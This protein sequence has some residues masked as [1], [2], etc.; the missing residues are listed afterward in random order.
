MRTIMTITI[1][2]SI[3]GSGKTTFMINLINQLHT[4]ALGQS[5]NHPS[6]ELPR[7]LYVAPLLSEVDRINEKCPGLN[8]RDP[9]PKEGRKLH[10]LSTLID[11]GSNI[12]TTHAL[13]RLLTRDI[14]EKLKRQNYTLIIDE[15][16]DCVNLFEGLSTSDRKLL[17]KD[18]CVYVDPDS[19][20]LRWNHRDH[21]NYSGEFNAIRDL[22]DNGNLV[23]H[24][25]KTL[26]WEFPT[27]FLKCF[28]QVYVLTYMFHGSPMSAYLRAEALTFEMM[29]LRDHQLVS[30]AE[31]SNETWKKE[32]LRKLITV[33]DGPANACGKAKGREN[34]FSSG[35]YEKMIKR[36]PEKLKAVKATTEHWFKSMAQTPA[37][38]NAWTTLKKAR[39]HLKGDR[40]ARGFIPNNAK[41]TNA[42]REKKS[43]AYLCNV[44]PNPLIKGYF[45]DRKT[46]V[47]DDLYAL[48][49]M[50]QWIWRTQI[51]DDQPINVFIPSE[52]MRNLFNR[53]L[54]SAS[55]ADLIEPEFKQAA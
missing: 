5:F 38:D 1:I 17:F 37:S 20:R 10:H 13:F 22:C 31:H 40:Y 55:V 44:F 33:Y 39:K 2:D 6:H 52:R 25:D 23:L 3:M 45:E 19:K 30:W 53:W 15:V 50:I 42:Y 32:E 14:Y 21:P 11:E 8:F 51:R 36:S 54:S 34:P 26:I 7:F 41:A 24:G 9:Q 28:D 35:W 4:E 48:S 29:T 18:N 12:C 43:V 16:L 49:E 27:D 46:T 47:Y